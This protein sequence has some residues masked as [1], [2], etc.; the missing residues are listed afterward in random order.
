[1]LGNEQTIV[2]TKS[3]VAT[4][5]IEMVARTYCNETSRNHWQPRTFGGHNSL[6]QPNGAYCNVFSSL[7]K[8]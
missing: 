4:P 7:R 6:S 1:M 8:G 5:N 2:A 3:M